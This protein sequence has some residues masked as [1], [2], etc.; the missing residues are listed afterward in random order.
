VNHYY[1]TDTRANPAISD[2]LAAIELV[3]EKYPVVHDEPHPF[4]GMEIVTQEL[5]SADDK[6]ALGLLGG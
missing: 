1:R 3:R 2:Q 4:G 6:E 5:I